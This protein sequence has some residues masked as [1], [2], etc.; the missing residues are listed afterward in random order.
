MPVETFSRGTLDPWYVSGFIDGEGTFTYSRSSRNIGLYFAV[1]L[2][3]ADQPILEA[4]QEFFGGIGKIYPVTPRAALTPRSGM[5]KTANYFRVTRQ[6]DLERVVL[7][8]DRYPLK[9]SKAESFRIWRE[10][11]F[12]KRNFRKPPREQL[13]GLARQ[14]SASAKNQKP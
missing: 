11:V 7:H 2:G 3:G 12:L 10:M 1:K 5:T 13:D 14:L 8:F 9:T 4:L 6:K